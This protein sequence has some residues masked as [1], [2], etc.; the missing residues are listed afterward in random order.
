VDPNYQDEYFG[1]NAVSAVNAATNTQGTVRNQRKAFSTLQAFW[2]PNAVTAVN[3]APRHFFAASVRNFPNP[4]RSGSEPTRFV[5]YVNDAGTINISIY[6]ASGQFVTSLPPAAAT[7]PGRYELSW[8]GRNRQGEVVS[9]GLYYA[10]IE[11]HGAQHEDKQF[12]KVVA[13]K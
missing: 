13:V 10:R 6:D 4:F 1:I 3:A 5:A 8:D 2:N 11:G 7:G 9:S 12:R